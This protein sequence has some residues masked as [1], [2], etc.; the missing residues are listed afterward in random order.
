MF[1][2]HRVAPRAHPGTAHVGVVRVHRHQE[3]DQS[4]PRRRPCRPRTTRWVAHS[5]CG[6]P[7]PSHRPPAR[8]HAATAPTSALE[9]YDS[10]HCGRVRRRA[11]ATVR[12]VDLVS[13]HT[14]AKRQ[15]RTP[16][17][18][19]MF[20]QSRA[21]CSTINP[22]SPPGPQSQL[23]RGFEHSADAHS[24]EP[25]AR[26]LPRLQRPNQGAPCV[27]HTQTSARAAYDGR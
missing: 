10:N 6:T 19:P 20:V 22:S 21:M 18:P 7:P 3:A 27:H 4:G 5:N 8:P 14:C 23:E 26:A 9:S 1:G 15:P 11:W 16:P 13:T 25:P 17:L 12:N 24:A 2:A